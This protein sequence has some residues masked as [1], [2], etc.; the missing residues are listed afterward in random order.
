MPSR[1][2]TADQV[3]AVRILSLGWPVPRAPKL[4]AQLAAAGH[5]R[6]L[7]GADV[8]LAA[9]ARFPKLRRSDLDSLVADAEF[10]VTP[11]ARGCIYLV[12]Q[13]DRA[14]CLSVARDLSRARDERD[15]KKAGIRPG[16][17]DAVAEAAVAA[18]RTQGPLTTD[19]LRRELGPNVVRSLGDAGKKVGVSSTLPPALRLLEFAGR[20]VRTP[21]DGQLDHEK[22]EWR[23]TDR[24]PFAD[25]AL[26]EDAPARHGRLL[27][28]FVARAG[29]T[30]LPLFA[31]WSG[32]AQRDAKLALAHAE[33]ELVA[34]E[35][36]DDEAL[37][38]PQLGSLLKKLA[39]ADE[40]IALLPFEDNLVHLAGGL[41][42]FV[43]SAAHDLKVPTWG[44]MKQKNATERLGDAKHVMFRSILAEG[45]VCGFWEYDPDTQDV[46][47]HLFDPPGKAVRTAIGEAAADL[48]T[49]LRGQLGHGHSFSLDTDDE[50]RRRTKLLCE[51][52]R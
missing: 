44:D 43:D 18:L 47:T 15:A 30:T 19:G 41:G 25:A 1:A 12:P 37:A 20:I 35:G 3:R 11:A 7:G 39:K 10:C 36:L 14:L 29:V 13:Q 45:R 33:H 16:E 32:L 27:E 51:M 42:A 2:L 49:F 31:A 23:A 28:H 40:Q 21:V 17:L 50:L 24:D 8:Y 9:R 22:Y 5:L 34:A 46:V 48:A 52:G 6:T 26:P 38:T 4:P